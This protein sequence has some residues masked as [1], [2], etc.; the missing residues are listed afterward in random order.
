MNN[1]KRGHKM[2]ISILLDAEEVKILKKRAK[3]N[4]MS[5]QE[6][7]EDILRRSCVSSKKNR[8][9]KDPCDDRL[10]KIFSKQNKGPRKGSKRKKK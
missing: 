3:G 1:I 6:Q 2:R 9:P 7:C 4:L 10:V 8:R 5:L